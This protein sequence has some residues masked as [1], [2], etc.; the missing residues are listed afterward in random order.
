[1]VA[2][3]PLGVHNHKDVWSVAWRKDPTVNTCTA[4]FARLSAPLKDIRCDGNP[5]LTLHDPFTLQNWTFPVIEGLLIVGAIACLLHA[6]R[7]YRRHRDASNLVVWISLISALLLIEPMAYF[8]QWFG[9]AKTMG[10]TFVHGQF[11][12]QVFYDRMP[13]YIVAMYPV[14]GYVA[15]VLAQR[16]GVFKT[17]NA[18]VGG[19][20]VAF[21]FFCLY[22][23]IDTVGPQWRWWVWNTD[24]PISKPA[25]GAV[26]YLNL[27]MFS[28]VLPFG[29]AFVARLVTK[30][31]HRGGW[32]IVRDVA[33]VSVAVWPILLLAGLPATVLHLT[34]MSTITARFVVTWLLIA[35][36]AV[37]A[38]WAFAGAY[39]AR[40]T[41]PAIVA[42]GTQGDYFALAC[43]VVYL[44]FGAVFWG[45]ALPD[46]L[47]AVNG[48]TA[49]GSPTGSL[50]IA[51][52]SFVLSIAVLFGAYA[53][54][55]SRHPQSLRSHSK[56]EVPIDV[57]P[58][59]H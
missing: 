40:K 21:V 10:L 16:A 57:V 36:T 50:P 35:G 52:I 27:Q 56:Q 20:C 38:V 23:I 8:P 5:L 22:E 58:Q 24:L 7:R 46:Y 6:V 30:A 32:F 39:R 43:V 14:F 34:G 9:I 53:G 2:T 12:V 11:S 45:A 54:N 41:D 18:F 31:P 37:I 49:S 1:M 17:Y 28:V 26:P 29:I 19:T 42:D 4:D 47:E 15:Y 55:G 3:G 33:V 13:L 51:A 44:A 59:D 48:I 25:L